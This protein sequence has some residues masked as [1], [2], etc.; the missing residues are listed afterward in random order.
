MDFCNKCFNSFVNMPD[1]FCV[2]DAKAVCHRRCKNNVLQKYH[3]S[4]KHMA[5]ARA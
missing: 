2:T 3:Q 4:L 5:A 1:S